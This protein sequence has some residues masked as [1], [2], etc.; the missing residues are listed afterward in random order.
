M[1][2]DPVVLQDLVINKFTP[3]PQ[4]LQLWLK[5]LKKMWK[6]L[7]RRNL[8]Q[9]NPTR[10]VLFL[11]RVERRLSGLLL[12]GGMFAGCVWGK[13]D[14]LPEE[15]EMKKAGPGIA[16]DHPPHLASRGWARLMRRMDLQQP[17]ATGGSKF[18]EIGCC[19]S[20]K[21][22]IPLLQ[23]VEALLQWPQHQQSHY[24]QSN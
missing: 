15:A 23:R 10:I 2:K 18:G 8:W 1:I 3:W 7:T 24:F 22:P 19:A 4:S 9:E 21:D 12:Q 20:I 17:C 5:M 11:W 13:Q 16:L 6:F 14:Q